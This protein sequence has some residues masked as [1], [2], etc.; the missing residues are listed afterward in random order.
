VSLPPEEAETVGAA[1]R[2]IAFLDREIVERMVA[3]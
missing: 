3:K 1:L 2:H